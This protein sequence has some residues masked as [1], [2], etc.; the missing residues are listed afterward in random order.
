MG[1]HLGLRKRRSFSLRLMPGLPC[2]RTVSVELKWLPKY[3]LGTRNY[4]FQGK[5]QKIFH[6]INNKH[7]EHISVEIEHLTRDGIILDF[8]NYK[9]N[10]SPKILFLTTDQQIIN[11]N[12]VM[13]K[14]LPV[15]FLPK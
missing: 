1:W 14:S 4:L 10:P 8:S 13:Q 5:N 6:I 9:I 11:Y 12:S 3:L 7:P 2:Q 15:K